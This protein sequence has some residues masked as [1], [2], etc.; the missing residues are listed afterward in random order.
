MNNDEQ[1]Q[2]EQEE[3]EEQ[4]LHTLKIEQLEDELERAR[5]TFPDSDVMV[6]RDHLRTRI[7]IEQ[8]VYALRYYNQRECSCNGDC[9]YE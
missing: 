7:Q 6:Y 2:E 9:K 1:E 5:E 4:D 8:C 3:R